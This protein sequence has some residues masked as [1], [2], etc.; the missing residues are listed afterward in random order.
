MAAKR[1]SGAPHVRSL[2]VLNWNMAKRCDCP[3]RSNAIAGLTP[4]IVVL[5]GAYRPLAPPM[6]WR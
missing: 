6:H 4:D 3:A 5:A 1:R 2:R